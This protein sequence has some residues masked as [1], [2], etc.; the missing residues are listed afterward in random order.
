MDSDK[1]FQFF[2]SLQGDKLTLYD[3]LMSL[4]AHHPIVMYKPHQAVESLVGG[5]GSVNYCYLCNLSQLDDKS[6]EQIAVS[7]DP[8]LHVY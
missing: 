4:F 5:L 3:S 2:L 1:Y 8:M 6:N 7:Q